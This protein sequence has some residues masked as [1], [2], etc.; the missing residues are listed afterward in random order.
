MNANQILS[1]DLLDLIFTDR[2][3]AYGAYELRKSYDSRIKK[4]LGITSLVLLLGIGGHLMARSYRS[5][6]KPKFKITTVDPIHLPPVDEPPPPPPPPAVEPPP[7]VRTIQWTTPVFV[8]QPDQVPPTV[9]DVQDARP[10][11]ITTEGV[12]D[13][14]IVAPPIDGNKGIIEQHTPVEP[15]IFTS[16]EIAANFK[17][18]WTKF[19]ERNLN[20]NV[21]VDNGAPAG[22]YTVVIQ[23]VVDLDGS[24]SDITA[25]S[26][27]GYGMEQEA[28]RVLKKADK[29][30]PGIQN[31]RAVKSYRR[32]PITFRI[33]E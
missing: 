27:M 11:V 19:L 1:A 15:E 21:P 22:S 6:D 26:K 7:P 8:E 32:Q 4:A 28:I 2:N 17:G 24:V 16:V 20:G 25:L 23:F 33:D 3:K 9:D 13:L 18:N 10:D 14:N 31:G 12:D 5:E 30:E 29:W